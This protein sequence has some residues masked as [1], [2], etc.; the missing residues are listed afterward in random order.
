MNIV[1]SFIYLM[2]I[3]P[4]TLMYV[5]HIANRAVFAFRKNG[6]R[7]VPRLL[8]KAKHSCR[9]LLALL[10]SSVLRELVHSV[11]DILDHL[12]KFAKSQELTDTLMQILSLCSSKE[13]SNISDSFIASFKNAERLLHSGEADKAINQLIELSVDSLETLTRFIDEMIKEEEKSIENPSI[14]GNTA[15]IQPWPEIMKAIDALEREFQITKEDAI[16]LRRFCR[17]F[18]PEIKVAFAAYE[19]DPH[20]LGAELRQLL[21]DIRE[22]ETEYKGRFRGLQGQRSNSSF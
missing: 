2:G 4:S 18:T 20:R 16:D 9:D 10:R 14:S 21:H 22:C 12:I 15:S 19:K 13:V 5:P 1:S 17:S 6:S 11:Y 7:D 3:V 8:R